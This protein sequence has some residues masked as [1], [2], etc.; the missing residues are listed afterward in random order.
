MT[1]RGE[2][3][4]PR[5]GLAELE[6]LAAGPPVPSAAWWITHQACEH[7]FAAVARTDPRNGLSLAQP[8]GHL[9]QALR[10]AGAGALRPFPADRLWRAADFAAGPLARLLQHHRHRILRSHV[11]LPLHRAREVDARSVAWLIAQPGRTVREK[12]ASRQRMLAVQRE[13]SAD[14]MEN[15]MLAVFALQFARRAE[16][17]LAQADAYDGGDGDD[18]RRERLAQVLELC[19]KRMPRSDLG[20]L[21][22]GERIRPNNVLLGDPLYS[23]VYRAWQW[24]R[25]EEAALDDCWPAALERARVALFWLTAARLSVLP[26]ITFCDMPARVTDGIVPG[27]ELLCMVSGR[28]EWL[29][30]PELHLLVD[31]PRPGRLP[32]LLRLALK[33]EGL[34]VRFAKIEGEGALRSAQG[35]GMR[36]AL[37]RSAGAPSR[38][39][40]VPVQVQGGEL[41]LDSFADLGGLSQL[42]ERVVAS[43]G[44]LC[45][46]DTRSNAMATACAPIEVAP[47]ATVHGP[48]ALVIGSDSIL[49][50]NGSALRLSSMPWAAAYDLPEREPAEWLEGRRGRVAGLCQPA[51]HCIDEVLTAPP[52]SEPASLAMTARLVAAA[53]ASE[54][55]L[56]PSARL[57]WT[58]PDTGDALSQRTLRSAMHGV[59]PNAVPVWRSVAAA[60]GWLGENLDAAKTG[61]EVVVIDTEFSSA[62]IT[63]LV[64][65]H[66]EA[67]ASRMP[68]S[69]G[70]YWER[71]PPFPETE[72]TGQL[73][74]PNVLHAYARQLVARSAGATL[75]PARCDA[76]AAQLVNGGALAALLASVGQP[77]LARTAGEADF[78]VLGIRHDA[79]LFNDL[80]CDWMEKLKQL[81]ADLVRGERGKRLR[82]RVL[83][84]GGPLETETRRSHVATVAR[85][86]PDKGYAFA[87]LAGTGEELFLHVSALAP[88]VLPGIGAMVA[89]NVGT[90]AKGKAAIDARVIG[91][92][93]YWCRSNLIPVSS[94]QIAAGA[95]AVALRQAAQC[96]SWREWLPDLL[97]EVVRNGHVAHV[98][99]LG[100][101]RLVDPVPGST[102]QFTA[103]SRFVMRAGQPGYALPVSEAGDSSRSAGWDLRIQSGLLPLAQDAPV[104]IEVRHVYGAQVSYR[105]TLRPEGAGAPFAALEAQPVAQAAISAPAL[106]P[107]WFALPRL[108]GGRAE[109][110]C[111]SLEKLMGSGATSLEDLLKSFRPEERSWA[112]HPA[113]TASARQLLAYLSRQPASSLGEQIERTLVQ[114][115]VDGAQEQHGPL[116]AELDAEAGDTEAVPQLLRLMGLAVGAGGGWQAGVLD[117]LMQRQVRY[118]ALES[119]NPGYRAAAVRAL[120]RAV[121]REPALAASLSSRPGATAWLA[122]DC[123][124]S[125]ASLLPRVPHE[126]NGANEEVLQKVR[127]RYVGP[128]VHACELLLGLCMKA[129][130]E[131]PLCT[132][133]EPATALARLIRQLDARFYSLG[134][135]E[136]RWW[137]VPA[138]DV[139][140]DLKNL[141]R[142]AYALSEQLAPGTAQALVGVLE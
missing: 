58:M 18:A 95:H 50:S 123:M 90:G 133:S 20:E 31:S 55:G 65:R 111:R 60:M 56:A 127:M 8:L 88:A 47:P 104:S 45:G 130:R 61:D 113:V 139:P 97:L 81:G 128:Y 64:A 30:E 102:V 105:L 10:H 74:W 131:G 103:A 68:G 136:Q 11:E 37:R 77:L 125:L 70:L 69:A 126:A 106:D 132:A 137:L 98:P 29:R 112:G 28:P 21:P 100:E 141:S 59:F 121:W 135:L 110:L 36:F 13:E 67:L 96:I 75:A 80:V 101:A 32:Q 129:G 92:A 122:A 16:A 86:N 76:L 26:N 27:V 44:R 41:E 46:L 119:F 5:L 14:T 35:N 142:V 22:V 40:G 39:R 94:R 15:R 118:G 87:R 78:D 84:A 91:D 82:R 19:H 17:R 1:Q 107:A 138:L 49:V 120:S 7:L 117:R 71:K 38:G 42:A 114:V 83:V 2:A 134:L 34:L 66:D 51:V 12:L 116:I 85:S 57:A 53:S 73:G 89:C 52:G 109:R 63:L 48:A 9:L 115:A 23:R 43:V 33:G 99:L 4:P 62:T 6:S 108:D 79:V 24:L 93:E 124:R 140:T 25:E 3:A 72:E 54:L